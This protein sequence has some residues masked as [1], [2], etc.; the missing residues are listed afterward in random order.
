MPWRMTHPPACTSALQTRC[1]PWCGA[2]RGRF[3]FGRMLFAHAA[4]PPPLVAAGEGEAPARACAHARPQQRWRSERW[5]AAAVGR[6]VVGQ[7][8]SRSVSRSDRKRYLQAT[9][10][11]APAPA[12]LAPHLPGPTRPPARPAPRPTPRPVPQEDENLHHDRELLPD[13]EQLLGR[14][15]GLPEQLELRRRAA[16]AAAAAAPAA[17]AA[18]AEGAAADGWALWRAFKAGA[19]AWGVR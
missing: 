8:V 10:G 13:E 3:S 2:A 17:P 14:G 4:R 12:T 15:G 11:R 19:L 5:A 1:T 18:A 9:T 7:S 16:A 6:S